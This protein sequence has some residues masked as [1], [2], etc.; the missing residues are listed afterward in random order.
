MPKAEPNP[1][2]RPEGPRWFPSTHWS[3]FASLRAGESAERRQ[4][5]DF[6]LQRYWKPV[7]CYIRRCG[8]SEEDA[9]DLVQ[10][11]F[12]DCLRSGFFAKAD[13]AR[14][15]FRSLLLRS[16]QH[17]LAN[18]GRA[19]HAQKRRPPQGFVSLE[20]LAD[21]SSGGFQPV[22]YETPEAVFHRAWVSDLI[23]RV[24]RVLEQECQATGKQAHYELL[25][26]RIVLPVLEGSDRPRMSDL[27]AQLGLTEKE[28]CNRLLTARRA[29]L[30][31]LEREIRSYASSDEEVV[32]E[33]RDLFGFLAE[34]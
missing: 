12:V 33:L 27:A 6:L 21:S 11:F 14:G 13:R 28:A 8:W 15:R 5:L 18:A 19:A 20:K 16:L 7:Y 23:E 34:A 30:R 24:L 4:A 22:N 17:F 1:D 29:F 25:R 32:T 3:R 26:Q 10:E 31:L 2:P 9:K